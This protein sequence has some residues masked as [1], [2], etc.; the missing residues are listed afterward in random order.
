MA[1]YDRFKY[2]NEEASSNQQDVKIIN[3]ILRLE[4]KQ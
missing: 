1:L 3:S 4:N 2:V